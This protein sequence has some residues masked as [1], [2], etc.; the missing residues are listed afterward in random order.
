ME[1]ITRSDGTRV[2]VTGRA[3]LILRS[4]GLKGLKSTSWGIHGSN[5]DAAVWINLFD[6]YVLSL[7]VKR[8]KNEKIRSA[9]GLIFWQRLGLD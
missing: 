6:Q 3:E 7:S 2:E 1:G 9:G 4:G 8:I 5:P